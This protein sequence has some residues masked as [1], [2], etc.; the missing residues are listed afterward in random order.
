M[1]DAN[2]TLRSSSPQPRFGSP[3]RPS[4]FL[5]PLVASY[6]SH[7][8]KALKLFE[9]YLRRERRLSEHTIPNYLNDVR[10][11]EQWLELTGRCREAGH[12]LE[13]A[14][15]DDIQAYLMERMATGLRKRRC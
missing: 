15:R 11:L 3:N 8:S 14:R 2:S 9:S 5:V 10:Q 1:A 4:L 7:D 12:A 6:T 13:Q